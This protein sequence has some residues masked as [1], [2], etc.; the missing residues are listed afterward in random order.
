M[1]P[2]A[3]TVRRHGRSRAY[4]R[5]AGFR[6]PALAVLALVA[7]LVTWLV[8]RDSGSSASG[9]LAA[10]HQ[11]TE[12]DLVSL[13]ARV[14]HPVFW[15]G[16]RSGYTYELTENK[17][18]SIYIR[19]LPAGAGIGTAKGELTVATYPFPGSYDA[20]KGVASTNGVTPIQI[21]NGGFA[22]PTKNHPHSVHVSYPGVDYQVEVF[23]PDAGKAAALA[24]AGELVPI[25]SPSKPTSRAPSAASVADLRTL[26]S[27]L[28]H[29]IYWVGPRKGYTYEVAQSQGNVYLRYLP[30]GVN[31]GA[32]GVYLTVATYPFEG[33][34]QAL[35]SLANKKG[36][37]Q[38]QLPGGGLA[39]IDPGR[40]KNVHLAFPGS[41]VQVEIFD[42]SATRVDEIVRSGQISQLG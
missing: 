32:S 38:V 40:P 23:D 33:A 9:G 24:A 7:G 19:Y 42:S 16:Q 1:T 5:T 31:V 14:G 27:S 2:N 22:L 35:K 6:F 20:L 4:G 29:P 41:P 10:A 28:G 36:V 39:M 37:E 18:G 17:D 30:P 12:T 21:P 13:A 8:L 26:A 15:L 34:F 11:V 3:D 25:G